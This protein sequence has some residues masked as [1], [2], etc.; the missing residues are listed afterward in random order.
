MCCHLASEQ[1]LQRTRVCGYLCVLRGVTRYND[2]NCTYSRNIYIYIYNI[3]IYIYIRL[4]TMIYIYIMNIHKSHIWQS[5]RVY[6]P[7]LS[8][9]TLELLTRQLLMAVLEGN[10]R[11]RHRRLDLVATKFWLRLCGVQIITSTFYHLTTL[12]KHL[13]KH[14]DT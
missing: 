4:V 2:T 11:W 3:Y 6:I 7:A 5:S 12:R 9:H 13:I 1:K 8:L 10:A 14:T